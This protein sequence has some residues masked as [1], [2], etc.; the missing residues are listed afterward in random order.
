[1]LRQDPKQRPTIEQIRSVD[2]V[3]FQMRVIEMRRM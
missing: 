3:K 2:E 1:M